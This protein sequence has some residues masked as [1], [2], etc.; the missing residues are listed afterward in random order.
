MKPVHTVL[1]LSAFA[2]I[3]AAVGMLLAPRRGRE[4]RENIKDFLRS[5]YPGM[6]T[7][8]LEALADQIA[9]EVKAEVQ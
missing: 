7:R 3:G 8:R 1:A 6:K 9:R 4:T 5:H 2:S